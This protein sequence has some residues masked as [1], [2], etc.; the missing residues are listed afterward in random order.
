M[1]PDPRGDVVH[2]TTD[3]PV[4]IPFGRILHL[5]S[6]GRD[7]QGVRRAERRWEGVN[8]PDLG[9]AIFGPTDALRT[10]RFQKAMGLSVDGVYG[11]QTHLFLTPFFDQYAFLL[12]TGRPP[13]PPVA[14]LQLPVGFVPTHQTEGLPGYPAKDF[15]APPGATV[16]SPVDGTIRR[17]SGHDPAAGGV[18]GGA[19]GWS[20]YLASGN[21]A[22]RFLT[23]FGTRS[24]EEGDRVKQGDLL[25]TV[26]D[27][28]VAHM[29]SALSHVHYGL[30]QPV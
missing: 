18:P 29:A 4:P 27:A 26:C 6:H 21:G 1:T 3:P 10:R 9:L 28:G 11:P 25:G 16:G 17:L 22:D 30:R 20:I 7:V 23:H 13:K 12:Y 24:V 2:T 14:M 8:D 19:Y 15:F 5:G